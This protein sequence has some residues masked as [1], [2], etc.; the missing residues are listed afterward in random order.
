M[1]TAN[2]PHRHSTPQ[3]PTDRADPRHPRDPSD[4]NSRRACAEDHGDGPAEGPV[5]G[6]AG[7]V[8]DVAGGELQRGRRG[9]ARHVRPVAV[10][11][12][13]HPVRQQP[14]RR[15]QGRG[16]GGRHRRAPVPITAHLA[17]RTSRWTARLGVLLLTLLRW[18]REF[19]VRA[20]ARYREARASKDRGSE[21]V[22]KAVLA[23]ALLAAAIALAL[24]IRSVVEDYAGRIE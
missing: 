10:P 15:G 14:G 21:T 18:W 7:A 19:T 1:P 5:E 13:A 3:P 23:A 11:T 12:S 6:S 17:T 9:V 8:G 24:V 16:R 4:P 2:T 22:E 20:Q